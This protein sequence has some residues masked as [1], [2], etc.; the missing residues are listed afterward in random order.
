M[1]SNL[2]KGFKEAIVPGEHHLILSHVN[3]DGD[4]V[5]SSL[6]WSSFLRSKGVKTT[7]VLPNKFAD[8][9]A[10]IP[11]SEEI[12]FAES[13]TEDEVQDLFESIDRIH[14]LDF[15]ALSRI[16]WGQE[17]ASSGKP[18]YLIDHHQD[19]EDFATV[20]YSNTS[21]CATAEMVLDLILALEGEI[22]L[23]PEGATALYTGLLT[24]TGSFRFPS[25]RS[26]TFRYAADLIDL[27]ADN[28]AI[29]QRIFDTN[30]L[31]RLKLLGYCLS[32]G[33]EVL[34]EKNAAI[35]SLSVKTLRKYNYQQGDTE[36]IV[37]Y[38]LSVENIKVSVI[39]KEDDGFLKVSLRSK[40]DLPVNQIASKYFNGG[41]HKNAAGGRFDGNLA[42]ARET[43]LK[44]LDEL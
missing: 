39:F 44:A 20:A 10:W 3:P 43:L 38:P 13:M 34:E 8:F 30:S 36:G 32:N 14:C 6:G 33:M 42:Q 4:A 7:M 35:I 29:Y 26:K 24:D 16:K 17:I 12:R 23:S 31:N 5:G 41:G 1:D 15:N 25:T 11:G 40:G 22:K 37:N 9:L 19:P 27:G 2:I 18:I 21:S 28:G